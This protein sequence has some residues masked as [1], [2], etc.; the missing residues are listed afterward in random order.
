M[1][2]NGDKP[3]HPT[4]QSQSGTGLTKREYFAALAMQGMLSSNS[5]TSPMNHDKGMT[6]VHAVQMAEALLK[7]LEK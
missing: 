1:K 2:N 7:E 3:I 6:V 5:Q 4:G